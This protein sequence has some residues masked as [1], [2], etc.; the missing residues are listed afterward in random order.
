MQNYKYQSYSKTENQVI[1][2]LILHRCLR[3]FLDQKFAAQLLHR[4]DYFPQQLEI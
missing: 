1:T 2:C 3:F 4:F